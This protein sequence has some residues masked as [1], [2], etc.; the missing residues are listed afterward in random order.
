MSAKR[1]GVCTTCEAPMTL[2]GDKYMTCAKHPMRAAEAAAARAQG[3]IER[4]RTLD[5][6][7][8]LNGYDLELRSIVEDH[9]RDVRA[10]LDAPA[11]R[12]T[13][14]DETGAA[15]RFSGPAPSRPLSGLAGASP[16]SSPVPAARETGGE[17]CP[18]CSEEGAFVALVCANCE[19]T[20]LDERGL[21]YS[22]ARMRFHPPDP[23]PEPAEREG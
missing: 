16:E 4:V 1:H 19:E 3:V 10:A 13:D 14:H 7:L 21:G 8:T 11:A 17:L 18:S 15:A 6:E 2:H 23:P 20:F 9:F 5:R 12:D 22:A